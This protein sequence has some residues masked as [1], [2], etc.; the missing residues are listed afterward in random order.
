[1]ERKRPLRAED[2]HAGD[3]LR[4]A[5][6]GGLVAHRRIVA[7]GRWDSAPIRRAARRARDEGRLIDLTYGYACQWVLFLD[8][9]HLVLS[10]EPYFAQDCEL[11]DAVHLHGK[12]GS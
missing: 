8:S 4:R 12:G 11:A 5:G 3:D 1:M 10:R 2:G 7:A 6:M 9:G